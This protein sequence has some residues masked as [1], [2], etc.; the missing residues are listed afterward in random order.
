MAAVYALRGMGERGLVAALAVAAMASAMPT[1]LL[2]TGHAA[3]DGH[4]LLLLAL[5]LYGRATRAAPGAGPVVALALLVPLTLF[6]HPYLMA[7]IAALAAAVPATLAVRGLRRGGGLQAWRSAA[8]AAPGPAAFAAW[9]PTFAAVSPAAFAAW[10]PAAFAA[11]SIAAGTALAAGLA[12]LFGYLGGSVPRDYGRYSMNLA[13]PFW[14]APSRLAPGL[15]PRAVDGTGGQVFEGLQYLGAGLLLLLL[16]TVARRRGR[17]W[18]VGCAPRHAGLLGACVMLS[19]YAVSTHVYLFHHELLHLRFVPPGGRLLRASGRLFWPVAYVLLLAAVRGTALAWPRA[20]AAVLL[21]GAALQLFDGSTLREH[22]HDERLFFDRPADA[23]EAALGDVIGHYRSVTLLP[24]L[25]CDGAGTSIAMPVIF[26]AARRAIPINTMYAAR[27]EA[28]NGCDPVPGADAR[29]PLARDA[30]GIAYGPT[31]AA[32]ALIWRRA[33]LACAE[34]PEFTLCAADPAGLAELAATPPGAPLPA[35]ATVTVVRRQLFAD[36]LASGW[37]PIEPW[38]AW[39]VTPHPALQLHVAPSNGPVR[40]TLGLQAPPA[41]SDR[42]IG[43][44]VGGAGGAGGAGG[45]L[46]ATA[47]L[48]QTPGEV[49]FVLPAGAARSGLIPLALDAGPVVALPQVP[50]VFGVGLLS[51]RVDP[52]ASP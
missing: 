11:L 38:G 51:V 4:F 42:V 13:T 6:V 39:A 3:L 43:V 40:V 1:F 37:G 31:R 5:G 25:E 21:A 52:L 10:R 19:A 22:V 24:R 48:G 7:M 28:G 47:H 49:H 27:V 17:R 32:Q 50:R 16:A 15:S 30:L 33:G 14:P 20:G 18:L 36:S 9:R 45:Q 41:V 12:G 23:S 46:V 26:L 34:L 2:R 35:G 8:F 29:R 44:R